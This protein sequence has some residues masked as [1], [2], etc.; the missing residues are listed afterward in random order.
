MIAAFL[1]VE[2]GEG[3]FQRPADRYNPLAVFIVAVG[4]RVVG[5]CDD[6]SGCRV[7]L[8]VAAVWYRV[9]KYF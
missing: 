9:D 1:R 7:Q 3:E 8:Y 6:A 5:R 2:L 4:A